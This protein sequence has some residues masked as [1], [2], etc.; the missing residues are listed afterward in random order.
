[1]LRFCDCFL[2]P[3]NCASGRGSRLDRP[4]YHAHTRWNSPLQVT[5]AATRRATR[6]ASWQLMTPKWKPSTAAVNQY[7]Q[8]PQYTLAI[9][10]VHQLRRQMTSSTCTLLHWPL[11]LTNDLD[12]GHDPYTHKN[13]GRKSAD[14]RLTIDFTGQFCNILHCRL[15]IIG[16]KHEINHYYYYNRYFWK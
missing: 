1:M 13:D 14:S 3:K 8:V 6:H 16:C 7:S 11:T 5:A 2:T 15:T 4:H 10:L 9:I 12:Y